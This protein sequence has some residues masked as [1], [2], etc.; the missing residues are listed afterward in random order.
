MRDVALRRLRLA[1]R[2]VLAVSL[3]LT[4]AL[5]WLAAN[6]FPGKTIKAPAAGGGT[7]QSA[8]GSSSSAGASSEGSSSSVTSP[9]QAPQAAEQGESGSSS[10]EQGASQPATEAPVVSGGS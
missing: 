4:G 9:E 8:A 1:K 10:G 3:A 2:W 7:G 5:A 6:A